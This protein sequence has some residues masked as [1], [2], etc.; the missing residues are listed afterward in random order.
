[1]AIATGDNNV[2]FAS[3]PFDVV[4]LDQAITNTSDTLT[5]SVL[6]RSLRTHL[7][8]FKADTC[9]CPAPGFTVVS[10][11]THTAAP[12]RSSIVIY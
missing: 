6:R 4:K 10:I 12:R 1:M 3:A 8:R 7:S 9:I 2:G 5:V 11:E